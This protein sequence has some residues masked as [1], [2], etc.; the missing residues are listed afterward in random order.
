M[1]KVYKIS[2]TGPDSY[3]LAAQPFATPSTEPQGYLYEGPVC[4]LFNADFASTIT[5]RENLWLNRY[6]D[7][8]L[9]DKDGG[10]LGGTPPTSRRIRGTHA[11][12]PGHSAF[13]DVLPPGGDGDMELLIP[14]I[15]GHLW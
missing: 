4:Q 8:A 15:D 3:S 9:V 10:A 5:G 1:E 11:V 12:G 7:W 2:C 14:A 6:F 13:A